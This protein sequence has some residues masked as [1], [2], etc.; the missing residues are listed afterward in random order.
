M[1]NKEDL[2]DK[3]ER[4]RIERHMTLLEMATQ[5]GFKYQQNWLFVKDTHTFS[6][7]TLM[8]IRRNFPELARDIDDFYCMKI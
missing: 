2:I 3:L 5:L 8:H 6:V 7:R 1:D 4:I